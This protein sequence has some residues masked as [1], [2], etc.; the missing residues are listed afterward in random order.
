M[1]RRRRWGGGDGERGDG[2]GGDGRALIFPILASQVARIAGVAHTGLKLKVL[3]PQVPKC[4]NYRQE[5]PHITNSFLV[6][7]RLQGK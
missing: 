5:P 6:L 1:G 3:L 7:K 2:G 4:W